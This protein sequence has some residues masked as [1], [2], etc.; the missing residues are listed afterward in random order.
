M[1]NIFVIQLE[2][3]LY[4]VGQVH[5]AE[6]ELIIAEPTAKGGV[7][8]SRGLATMQAGCLFYGPLCW[9]TRKGVMVTR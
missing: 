4:Q 9:C 2:Q 6:S 5:S 3:I 1:A 7:S 8:M